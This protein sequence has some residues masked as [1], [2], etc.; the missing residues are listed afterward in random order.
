VRAAGPELLHHRLVVGAIPAS[1]LGCLKVAGSPGDPLEQLVGGDLEVL[2]EDSVTED[3]GWRAR[4]SSV[5]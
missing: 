2:G 5:D 3:L 1:D 4:V